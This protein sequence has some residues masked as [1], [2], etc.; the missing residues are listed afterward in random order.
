MKKMFEEAF[1][2]PDKDEMESY[3]GIFIHETDKAIL[4]L[5]D[6]WDDGKE[7]WLPKSKTNW[8]EKWECEKG[9]LIEIEIPN[10]LAEEKG[11]L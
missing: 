11:L 2:K 7:I 4:F 6:G 5:P 3:D 8:D 10:W 9:D 1:G